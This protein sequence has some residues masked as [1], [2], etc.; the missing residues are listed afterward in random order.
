MRAKESDP[1]GFF[2]VLC[3]VLFCW[4][5]ELFALISKVSSL[6]F[7]QKLHRQT[8]SQREASLGYRQHMLG[9]IS[10]SYEHEI[11]GTLVFS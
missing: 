5:G 9:L 6:Y 8:L 1:S 3:C 2:V 11:G 10:S 4:G 7:V